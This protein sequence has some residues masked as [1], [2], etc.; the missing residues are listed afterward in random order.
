[1][2][3]ESL[4]TP[5]LMAP[6]EPALAVALA[7]EADRASWDAYVNSRPGAT[8]Y[9]AWAWREVIERTFGHA[10]FYLMAR[11]D[12]RPDVAGVL[13]LVEIRSRLFGRTMTSLPFLNYGGIVADSE[14]VAEALLAKARDLAARRLE[15]REQVLGGQHRPGE[16]GCEV[17]R[18]GRSAMNHRLDPVELRA[19]VVPLAHVAGNPAKARFGDVRGDRRRRP[20]HRDDVVARRKRRSD[21]RAAEKAAGTGYQHLH[22]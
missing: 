20:A 4:S 9:H 6:P 10:A 12:G 13:P 2:L 17:T 21:R 15:C 3:A 16:L 18:G 5:D 7:G 8:G 11:V 19:P 22:A 1:M 14:A